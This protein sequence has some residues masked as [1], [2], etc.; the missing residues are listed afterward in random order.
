MD[1][2]LPLIGLCVL[3]ALVGVVGLI[4]TSLEPAQPKIEDEPFKGRY[5]I[6]PIV[7]GYRIERYVDLL[8]P[9]CGSRKMYVTVTEMQGS[10]EDA[11]ATVAHLSQPVEVVA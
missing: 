1:L 8:I 10:I 7:G 9:Y 4:R 3:G 5:R 6:T 2:T 11:R